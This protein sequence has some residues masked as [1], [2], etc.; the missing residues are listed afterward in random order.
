MCVYMCI[1]LM[2]MCGCLGVWVC[3]C[4][5]VWVCGCVDVWVFACN[6]KLKIKMRY[7]KDEGYK[8]NTIT[9]YNV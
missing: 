5:G 2:W 9:I 7:V 3:G 4:V 1:F 6:R 8:I